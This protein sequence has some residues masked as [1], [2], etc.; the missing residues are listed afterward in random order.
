M[1]QSSLPAGGSVGL[2][3]MDK[4]G[5]TTSQAVQNADY[6]RALQGE[7]EGTIGSIT[8]RRRS[9]GHPGAADRRATS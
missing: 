4:E 9:S 8:R 6:Q 3:L 7:L 1:A 2:E 5:I